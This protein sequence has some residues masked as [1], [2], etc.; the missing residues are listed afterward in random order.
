MVDF[1]GYLV[2]GIFVFK[3]KCSIGKDFLR[4]L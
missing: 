1:S 2:K 3:G 4:C